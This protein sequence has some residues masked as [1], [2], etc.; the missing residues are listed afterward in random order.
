MR[1]LHQR[2]RRIVVPRA[3]L[4]L[5]SASHEALLAETRMCLARVPAVLESA[6]APAADLELVADAQ[7]HLDELFLVVVVGEFNSGKSSTINALL[8]AK[9]LRDGVTPTTS[10]ISILKY[11]EAGRA[12]DAEDAAYTSR[13]VVVHR[14]NVP[15]LRDINIV[16]TPGTNAVFE[17]H[18]ALTEQFVPRSDLVLFVTSA[19]RPFSASERGFLTMI[20]DWK[21]TLLMVINKVDLLTEP[22]DRA[23]VLDW[24]RT[25]TAQLVGHEVPLFALSARSKEGVRELE[26]YILRTLSGAERA[27]I[28]LRAPLEAV[29]QVMLRHSQALV[30]QTAALDADARVLEALNRQLEVWMTDLRSELHLHS[31]GLSNILLRLESRAERFLEDQLRVGNLYSLLAQREAIRAAFERDVAADVAAEVE[32]HLSGVVDWMVDRSSTQHALLVRELL[33]SIKAGVSTAGGDSAAAASAAGFSAVRRQLHEHML[34]SAKRNMLDKAAVSEHT[35]QALRQAALSFAALELGAVGL[36]SIFSVALLDLTGILGVGALAATGVAVLPYRKRQLRHQFAATL[37]ALRQRLT[38]DME[39]EFERHLL[40]AHS[41]MRKAMSPYSQFVGA[42]REHAASL[43]A[44]LQALDA[45]MVGL[46]EKVT[47]AK[48]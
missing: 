20:R 18:Q 45:T 37:E 36:S 33:Q 9:L 28:K 32:R 39:V 35:S 47:N 12:Y 23:T 22:A 34:A 43:G 3:S 27:A 4:S 17:Q 5:L 16:D 42:Q 11:G 30:V 26:E 10:R 15:W 21:R 8:G 2:C 44:S 25:N 41:Q 14:F 13:G 46:M 29:R 1:R 24:V 31:T 19:D 38:H 48:S 40:E 7:R 6:S